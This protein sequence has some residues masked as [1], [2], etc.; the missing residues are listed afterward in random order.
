MLKCKF[1]PVFEEGMQEE[2]Q[3]MRQPER[4]FYAAKED[5]RDPFSRDRDR[6]IHCSSFR[7]LEYKTQV[8]LNS[9]GDFFRT[10][11]THS[12]EVSQIARSIAKQ[13]GLCESLCEAIALAHDLGHTPFGHAGGDELDS[14][15]QSRCSG[16]RFDHNFQSFRVVQK[17]EKRYKDFDG[18]N[19][20]FATLEGILKHSAPY[21]KDF[22]SSE[23]AA[24]LDT[25]FGLALHPS[26]EA[27]V[28][29]YADEIA[30]T[31]HDIDDGLKCGFLR[32]DSIRENAFVQNALALVQRE[33][34]CEGDLVFQARF[35]TALIHAAITSLIAHSSRSPYLA[36]SANAAP[37][38][39]QIPSDCNHGIGLE[40]ALYASFRELKKILFQELYYHDAV[41]RKMAFGKRCVRALF[42]DL[43]ND[44]RLLEAPYRA[45][46]ERGAKPHRVVADFIASLSD[47]G[48]VGLYQELHLG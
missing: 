18:L 1:Y 23:L 2:W 29:D 28:V 22:F 10:R 7:R 37:Q 16:A 4:R 9:V 11:L 30:Y 24:Y 25:N 36:G 27:I 46:I 17:L 35:V 39:A 12:L 41:K 45:R 31:S 5:F 19:L 40:P 8:F 38:C 33:G 6:I 15:L 32:L 3:K 20:T 44:T 34:I 14:V 21:R 13:L 42:D 47:R 48:A 26:F 43:M